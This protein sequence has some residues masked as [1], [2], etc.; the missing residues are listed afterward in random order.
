MTRIGSF[1]LLTQ[2][3][4]CSC[5]SQ[6]IEVISP[7]ESGTLRDGQAVG[8][9]MFYD[10]IGHLSV[11]VDYEQNKL[12]FSEIDTSNYLVA[13]SNGQWQRKKLTIPTRF[14]GSYTR[15]FEYYSKAASSLNLKEDKLYW[16]V[17]TVDID[18]KAKNPEI[19]G[20]PNKRLKTKILETF[21]LA[22]NAWIPGAIGN[23]TVQTKFAMP[24]LIC[25]NKCDSFDEVI[26]KRIT[27]NGKVIFP[28]AIKL[29]KSFSDSTVTRKLVLHRLDYSQLTWTPDDK[30]V[31]LKT[32]ANEG[33][34]TY[35]FNTT[36]FRL[37]K[38]YYA[39]DSYLIFCKTDDCEKVIVNYDAKMD[40]DLIYEYSSGNSINVISKNNDVIHSYNNNFDRYLI[41]R[42]EERKGS[43]LI[44]V[45]NGKETDVTNTQEPGW[46]KHVQSFALVSDTSFLRMSW[47]KMMPIIE[48]FDTY[49]RQRKVLL[50]EAFEFLALSPDKTKILVNE[51]EPKL[52]ATSKLC[53]YDLKSGNLTRLTDSFDQINTAFFSNNMQDVFFSNPKKTF[54]ISLSNKKVT[55]MNNMSTPTFSNDE[56][57]M[58][59]F[60]KSKGNILLHLAN[61]D[62][63]SPVVLHSQKV[64]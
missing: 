31:L 49:R 10:S 56:T 58:V 2:I 11:G 7:Y 27:A 3:I 46:D 44:V 57:R 50:N 52:R 60:S 54:K 43:Q 1:F 23:E 37:E 25:E 28:I 13:S 34:Y 45:K 17:F 15:L 32:C 4:F 21:Q 12:L 6:T 14:V 48:L 39:P 47:K 16:L 38:I 33:C 9:W 29:V 53:L 19:L 30:H 40:Y 64:D 5:W 26:R 55:V 20:N 59:Y 35:F 36:T 8:K 18:G 22:P 42:R 61:S 63:S 62:G 51:M 24:I 41:V